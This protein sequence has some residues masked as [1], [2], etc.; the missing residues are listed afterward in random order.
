MFNKILGLFFSRGDDAE[1]RGT[2]NLIELTNDLDK[3]VTENQ[4]K[5]LENEALIEKLKVKRDHTVEEVKQ[6]ENLALKRC[7]LRSI[8]SLKERMKRLSRCSSIFNDNIDF[9][10]TMIDK[11]ENMRIAGDKC[12]TEDQLSELAVAVEERYQEHREFISDAMA[13]MQEPYE[14]NAYMDDP[15]IQS[16]AKECGL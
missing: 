12:V 7:K 1:R 11:L 6:L 8:F 2:L 10:I 5:Y 16:L 9:Q 14:T 3:L 4:I 13:V 15:E